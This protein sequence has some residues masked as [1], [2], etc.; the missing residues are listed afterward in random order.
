MLYVRQAQKAHPCPCLLALSHLG[1]PKQSCEQEKPTSNAPFYY[2]MAI[3]GIFFFQLKGINSKSWPLKL[4]SCS[5]NL[6]GINKFGL[7]HML[8]SCPIAH[9]FISICEFLGTWKPR[10]SMFVSALRG[11]RKGSGGCNCKFCF[12]TT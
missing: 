10:I 3:Q 7:C 8:E 11:T 1:A 6:S 5:K 4:M 2:L 12:T 9:T